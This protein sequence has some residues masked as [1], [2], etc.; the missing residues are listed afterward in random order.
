V[1]VLVVV[2]V[3]AVLE[4][5]RVNIYIVI[6]WMRNNSPFGEIS[7]LRFRCFVTNKLCAIKF[8]VSVTTD[9]GLG[10]DHLSCIEHGRELQWNGSGTR[11]YRHILR[12]GEE[13]F[14]RVGFAHSAFLSSL[15]LST[16]M[17]FRGKGHV[18]F[19]RVKL[20]VT[21]DGEFTHHFQIP[22][23]IER[24]EMSIEAMSKPKF[25]DLETIYGMPLREDANGKGQVLPIVRRA[26]TGIGGGVDNN[27]K[28]KRQ[29]KHHHQGYDDHD[30]GGDGDE[31]DGDDQVGLPDLKE[32]L[33]FLQA[34]EQKAQREREYVQQVLEPKWWEFVTCGLQMMFLNKMRIRQFVRYWTQCMDGSRYATITEKYST[35]IQCVLSATCRLVITDAYVSFFV[36]GGGAPSALPMFMVPRNHLM[37]DE[38]VFINQLVV[39]RDHLFLTK[40]V[41]HSHYKLEDFRLD[42]LLK[43]EISP[44]I[45]VQQFCL[46]CFD[47]MERTQDP[48][49]IVVL[50]SALSQCVVDR[51]QDMFVLYLR[52]TFDKQHRV[53]EDIEHVGAF[54]QMTTRSLPEYER[55]SAS[56]RRTLNGHPTTPLVPMS[57][58]ASS[59]SSL[60][61][62]QGK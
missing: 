22:L 13:M 50:L 58:L 16:T 33:S 17:Y 49:V 10:E 32:D 48:S 46:D 39:E 25:I 37:H 29:R 23:D 38:L 54:V 20:N 45:I 3:I 28:S 35:F 51:P 53:R 40:Y 52:H 31:E 42:Q 6:V 4:R 47:E 8:G 2:V 5:E 19:P 41:N 34:K 59:S 9:E 26:W 36:A 57:V 15:C 44:R 60:S 62:S 61:S 1:C 56:K 11:E 12:G 18:Y 21:E 43:A 24:Q 14:V 55:V 27:R 7:G 30:K